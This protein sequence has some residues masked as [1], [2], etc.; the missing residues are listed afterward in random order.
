MKKIFLSI[1]CFSLSLQAIFGLSFEWHPEN[2]YKLKSDESLMTIRYPMVFGD[3]KVI[4]PGYK[5]YPDERTN[6]LLY[7]IFDVASKNSLNLIEK[8]NCHKVAPKLKKDLKRLSSKISATKTRTAYRGEPI[9]NSN[10]FVEFI[11]TW[12]N[13]NNDAMYRIGSIKEDNSIEWSEFKQFTMNKEGVVYNADFVI[14]GNNYIF[15]SISV[16]SD[17]EKEDY[18][19][20]YNYGKIE[21]NEIKWKYDYFTKRMSWSKFEIL[22]CSL[23]G[24]FFILCS[25]PSTSNQKYSICLINDEGNL[26]FGEPNSFGN[27]IITDQPAYISDMDMIVFPG[28][29]KKGDEWIQATATYSIDYKNKKITNR[30]IQ[31]LP[32]GKVGNY[33]A[34]DYLPVSKKLMLTKYYDKKSFYYAL[35]DIKKHN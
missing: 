35:A 6:D 9:P 7:W 20:Y 28:E 12:F 33:P 23:K 34:L 8:I 26:A 15:G 16:A 2:K 14:T 11:F 17:H 32:S 10:S 13:S 30:I 18:V 24:S 5:V 27:F 1:F 31:D 25:D 22:A 3:G 21:N 19:C 4:E 29:Y